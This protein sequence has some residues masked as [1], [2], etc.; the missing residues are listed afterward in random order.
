MRRNTQR[1]H[2]YHAFRSRNTILK[3]LGKFHLQWY[4]GNMACKVLM[5][6]RILVIIMIFIIYKD[7]DY[8]QVRTG[9]YI[10][11]TRFQLILPVDSQNIRKIGRIT[12]Y[13]QNRGYLDTPN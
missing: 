5:M 3:D 4:A 11:M 6:V 8:Y 1:L 7:Y 2:Y 13:T 9:G 12:G 10:L